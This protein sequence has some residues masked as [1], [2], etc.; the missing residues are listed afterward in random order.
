MTL[1]DVNSSTYYVISRLKGKG[2]FVSD[3][4]L[5]TR[6]CQIGPG[7]NKSKVTILNAM[8]WA[9]WISQ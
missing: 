2:R 5:H 4:Y 8:L 6:I 7:K 9:G 3:S 1:F